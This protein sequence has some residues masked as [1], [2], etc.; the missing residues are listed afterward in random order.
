M[1]D[2]KNLRQMSLDIW[3][4]QGGLSANVKLLKPPAD[5]VI[6]NM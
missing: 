5:G 2:N 1:V 3:Q 4:G 6:N